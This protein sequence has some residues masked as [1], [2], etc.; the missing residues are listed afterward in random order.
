MK[1]IINE[2]LYSEETDEL[3]HD[4]DSEIQDLKKMN[5]YKAVLKA[6]KPKVNGFQS[7][8][9]IKIENPKKILDVFSKK[10]GSKLKDIIHKNKRK[11]RRMSED[12]IQ[13]GRSSRRNEEEENKKLEEQILKEEE[14]EENHGD[15]LWDELIQKLT[16]MTR[17]EFLRL[18]NEQNGINQFSNF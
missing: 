9:K 18:Q 7:E 4:G 15:F 17:N 14:E 16:Q 5:F 10:S 1:D 2:V 11:L 8:R 12:M 6:F 3:D 13:S